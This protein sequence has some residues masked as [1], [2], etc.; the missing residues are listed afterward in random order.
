VNT[1]EPLGPD[2]ASLERILKDAHNDLLQHV[3]SNADLAQAM[4][5]IMDRFQ[6]LDDVPLEPRPLIVSPAQATAT[7]KMRLAVREAQAKLARVRTHSL[8]I[9]EGID[10]V[11]TRPPGWWQVPW[12]HTGPT[13]VHTDLQSLANRVFFTACPEPS[14]LVLFTED[15]REYLAGDPVRTLLPGI[16]HDLEV[17]EIHLESAV[18]TLLQTTEIYGRVNFSDLRRTCRAMKHL[19]DVIDVITRIIDTIAGAL[20]LT[21]I[22]A[23][24]VDLSTLDLSDVDVLDG[25]RWTRV[26]AHVSDT[27]WPPGLTIRVLE[28]S[29]EIAPG[30]YQVRLGTQE[31]PIELART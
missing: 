16:A 11:L 27:T 2:D 10:H 21:L 30:V 19:I 6:V 13:P 8:A 7:I 18:T 5:A 31:I 1:S 26:A 12:Y 24:G 29:E 25:V 22:D 4:A 3:R 9:L 14:D 28:N 15:Q 23:S 20:R 17:E